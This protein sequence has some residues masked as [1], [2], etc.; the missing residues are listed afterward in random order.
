M[1][2]TEHN[3]WV[4]TTVF[5]ALIADEAASK[6]EIYKSDINTLSGVWVRSLKTWVM[7]SPSEKTAV[8][9]RICNKH[10]EEAIAQAKRI[11]YA[12]SKLQ[13]ADR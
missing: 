4:K 7:M 12:L 13:E 6:H 11:T 3:N 10:H 9:Q 5:D 2:V 8:L 1:T